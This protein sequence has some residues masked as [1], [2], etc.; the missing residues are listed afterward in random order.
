MAEMQVQ[1]LADWTH[2]GGVAAVQAQLDQAAADG[3]NLRAVV[4][5]VAYFDKGAGGGAGAYLP[6]T[7]GVLTGPVQVPAGTPA[8]PGIQ[9]GAAVNNGLIWQAGDILG[10]VV[11]GAVRFRVGPTG[12]QALADA[13][14]SNFKLIRL[15]NATAGTDALNMQTA[16]A[17][18]A[19]IAT[20]GAVSASGALTEGPASWTVDRTSAGQYTVTHNIGAPYSVGLAMAGT[21]GA[22]FIQLTASPANSF[23]VRTYSQAGALQDHDFEF[24]VALINDL[25]VA[26]LPA[27]EA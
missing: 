14:A 2:S 16:D 3:W 11:Q 26:P 25:T 22:G 21:G 17:R 23:E 19:P 12:P 18:Y 27:T 5:L 8:I 15:G 7:G 13:D 24:T 9:I 4:G 6:L 10:I 20:G 1:L